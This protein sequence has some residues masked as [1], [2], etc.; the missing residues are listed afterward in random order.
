M[1][2]MSILLFLTRLSHFH[3][4]LMPARNIFFLGQTSKN[5]VVNNNEVILMSL[6]PFIEPL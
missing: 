4:R 1:E 3:V 5:A 6:Y 2:L